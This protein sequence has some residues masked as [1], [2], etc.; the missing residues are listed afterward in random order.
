MKRT[1]NSPS[2][3]GK[4]VPSKKAA[5]NMK[6]IWYTLWWIRIRI[7]GGHRTSWNT[8]NFKSGVYESIALHYILHTNT[9]ILKANEALTN[10]HRAFKYSRSGIANGKRGARAALSMLGR[11]LGPPVADR[12]CAKEQP[13]RCL[14]SCKH[15]TC[16]FPPTTMKAFEPSMSRTV[17]LSNGNLHLFERVNKRLILRVWWLHA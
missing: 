6:S 16:M 1:T 8:L 12:T 7:A 5:G 15:W 13:L 4:W 17:N 2:N 3:L 10:S 11:A 9:Y 14:G